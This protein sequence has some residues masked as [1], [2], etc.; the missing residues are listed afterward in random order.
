M[1]HEESPSVLARAGLPAGAQEQAHPVPGLDDE[2]LGGQVPAQEP[3]EPVAEEG[4]AVTAGEPG[5]RAKAVGQVLCVQDGL[6][7]S[8]GSRL[9]T[10]L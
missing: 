1:E 10:R 6:R 4:L 2:V 7:K 5:G 9:D 8:E 3:P